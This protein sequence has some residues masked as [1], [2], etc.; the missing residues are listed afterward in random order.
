MNINLESIKTETG[1]LVGPAKELSNIFIDA[2]EKIVEL[3]MKSGKI[4]SDMTFVQLKKIPEIHNPEEAGD[5]FWGQIE[6]I[7]EFNKQLLSDW[8]ALM[9][10]NTEV[11]NDVKSAFNS[12]I[13]KAVEPEV[14]ET[15]ASTEK[16]ESI[17]PASKI[18]K[19]RPSART[20]KKSATED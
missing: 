4:Y 16:E 17:E 11:T 6:P 7:S 2:A 3:Q 19:A 10:L 18:T 13:S 5:F 15:T 14:V 8:K 12:K 1:K 20:T 9:A